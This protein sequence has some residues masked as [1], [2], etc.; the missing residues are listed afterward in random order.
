VRYLFVEVITAGLYCLAFYQGRVASPEALGWP[1]VVIASIVVADVVALSF[2]DIETYTVP[3]VNSVPLIALGLVLAPVWPVFQ[4][5]PTQWAG[6]PPLDRAL[7]SLQGII[8]GGGVVWAVG[9]GAELVLRKEAMGGGDVKILAGVGALFGWKAALI[10]FLIAVFVGAFVGVAAILLGKLFTRAVDAEETP[11][12]D[13]GIT[14]RYE[15]DDE[16]PP[17]DEELASRRWPAIVG[18]LIALQQTAML[19]LLPGAGDSPAAAAPLLCGATIG[20]FAVFYDTVRRRLVSEGRWIQ[21]DITTAEDGSSE[22]RLSGHYLPFG[23][24][25]ACASLVMLFAGQTVLHYFLWWFFPT[26]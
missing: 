17:S 4:I 1:F 15:P 22:E 8:L 13:E 6:I 3:F 9:A 2:V 16:P 10:S 21:R 7:N 18:V 25:L 5:A 23:P 12:A 24:F 19:L 11:K 20:A 26:F 14:Y